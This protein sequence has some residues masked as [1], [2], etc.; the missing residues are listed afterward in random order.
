MINS[1][2]IIYFIEKSLMIKFIMELG[3]FELSFNMLEFVN[4]LIF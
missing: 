4:L 2:N 1:N 3:Y